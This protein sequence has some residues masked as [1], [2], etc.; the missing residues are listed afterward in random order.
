MQRSTVHY[1]IDIDI[2]IGT[3]IGCSSVYTH[4]LV[5]A[6]IT[7]T[8]ELDMDCW[9]TKAA[10]CHALGYGVWWLVAASFIAARQL[11]ALANSHHEAQLQP[12]ANCHHRPLL[13]SNNCITA[14]GSNNGTSCSNS[15]STRQIAKD[16]TISVYFAFPLAGQGDYHWR[17]WLPQLESVLCLCV[18]HSFHSW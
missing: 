15:Y 14:I 17:N 9:P 2:D 13:A 16:I 12:H 8:V 3:H 10:T 5:S 1:S 11:D 4:G 6:F 7:S 18:V